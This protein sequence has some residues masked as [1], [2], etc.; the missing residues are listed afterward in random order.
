[1]AS[2]ISVH[3]SSNFLSYAATSSMQLHITVSLCMQMLDVAGMSGGAQKESQPNAL[4]A[5]THASCLTY[6]IC[7]AP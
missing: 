2:K 5:C 1:M 3:L 7:P 6:S 4:A